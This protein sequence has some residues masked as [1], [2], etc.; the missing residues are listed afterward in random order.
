MRKLSI[1]PVR[2][3]ANV[4]DASRPA[5]SGRTP[6]LAPP[7]DAEVSRRRE[8]RSCRRIGNTRTQRHVR[9]L[10]I[11]VSHPVLSNNAIEDGDRLLAGVQCPILPFLLMTVSSWV[12]RH[13]LFVL[14]FLQAENQLSKCPSS[15]VESSASVAHIPGRGLDFAV[16]VF[17]SV[18]KGTILRERLAASPKII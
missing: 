8:Y 15:V 6:P 16:H 14:E 3:R 9:A 13:Q 7:D 18:E 4:R 1:S 2:A 5:P 17:A 12:H 11:V 10:P